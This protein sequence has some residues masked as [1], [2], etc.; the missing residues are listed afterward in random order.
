MAA[1]RHFR[2]IRIL[3]TGA[4]LYPR[5]CCTALRRPPS[6]VHR[7][8]AAAP[9]SRPARSRGRACSA[10]VR[11][12]CGLC[13]VVGCG[14]MWPVTGAV[15][16]CA[17]SAQCTEPLPTII[18]SFTDSMACAGSIERCRAGITRLGWWW[19]KAGMSVVVGQGWHECG[20][21]SRVGSL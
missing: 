14:A 9:P 19:V 5:L 15:R 17:W 1:G 20:G 12:Q 7:T 10:G 18:A 2:T 6:L 11:E 13:L 3:G 8:R 16:M 4:G 21:E